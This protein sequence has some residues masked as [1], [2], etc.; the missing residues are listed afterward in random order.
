MNKQF[1]VRWERELPAA[2]QDV[3]DAVT[4]HAGAWLW[5]IS[6][7]PRVG[8]TE[9]GLSGEGGT[10]TAWDPPRHFQTRAGEGEAANQLDYVLTRTHNGTHVSYAH[11]GSVAVEDFDREL[12]ACELHTAF[13]AHSMAEYVR[14]FAG[15]EAAYLSADAAEGTTTAAV[16][17]SVG[18]PRDAMVGTAVRVNGSDG[19]VDYLTGSFVGVRTATALIRIYGRDPWGWPVAVAVHD[20]AGNDDWNDWLTGAV[21]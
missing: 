13:Y 12:D 17:E 6:F 7:E 14:H 10:V 8:G 2:P 19:V 21:R 4:L 9:Q 3:W 15:K 16:R 5:P 1:E 11:N 18:V 20:F